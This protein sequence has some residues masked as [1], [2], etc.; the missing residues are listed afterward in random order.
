[1]KRKIDT[2][3]HPSS[4][5]VASSGERLRLPHRG[6]L[7]QLQTTI[8]NLIHH[9]HPARILWDVLTLLDLSTFHEAVRARNGVRGR[10]ATDPRIHLGLWGMAAWIGISSARE[11]ALL[12]ESNPGLCWI[13]GGVTVNHPM[14]S[15]FKTRH[16]QYF[17]ATLNSALTATLIMAR[18]SG[19]C[20]AL[21]YEQDLNGP[22]TF[23]ETSMTEWNW[24]RILADAMVKRLQT[25]KRGRPSGFQAGQNQRGNELIES[26]RQSM[27]QSV[28]AKILHTTKSTRK[29]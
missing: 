7:V 28:L 19:W 4:N 1:M 26:R 17:D 11:I 16:A 10:D 27:A 29:T 5:G 24:A 14:M 6:Q 15:S 22:V 13:R 25:P 18:I 12:A 2:E 21:V 20:P 9:T 8:D 23:I 3:A